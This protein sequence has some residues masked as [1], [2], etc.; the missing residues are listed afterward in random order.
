MAGLSIPIMAVS[1]PLRMQALQ[2]E[3]ARLNAESGYGDLIA[4]LKTL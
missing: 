1:S 2:T 3:S 4:F